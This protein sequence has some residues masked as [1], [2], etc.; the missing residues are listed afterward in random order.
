MGVF[1]VFG[2]FGETVCKSL[3]QSTAAETLYF[4]ARKSTPPAAIKE[5]LRLVKKGKNIT[6]DRAKDIV[7][8]HKPKKSEAGTADESEGERETSEG[9]NSSDTAQD[10][11]AGHE[12]DTEPRTETEESDGGNS[13]ESEGERE[14]AEG[15]DASDTAEDYGT[16][17]EQD[18]EPTTETE[19]SIDDDFTLE[20][21]DDKSYLK[22]FV[23]SV[24]RAIKLWSVSCNED[25]FL[26]FP[27]VLRALAHELEQG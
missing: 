13:D 22:H 16:G 24:R 7:T 9:D 6:L 2:V 27:R 17:D 15:D 26:Q 18:A 25:E 11:G 23:G 14:T 19:Q 21:I 8:K 1:R 10:S 12:Q 20:T 3:L 4:L 5:V